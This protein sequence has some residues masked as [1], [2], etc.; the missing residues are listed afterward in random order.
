MPLYRLLIGQTVSNFLFEYLN[1]KGKTEIEFISH[2]CL[3]LLVVSAT[4]VPQCCV[5]FRNG[6]L[7]QSAPILAGTC[8]KANWFLVT[9]VYLPFHNTDSVIRVNYM[10]SENCHVCSAKEAATSPEL[11]TFVWI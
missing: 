9:A 8:H 6:V 2:M 10:T 11:L 5:A 3:K 4:L 1:N 7:T